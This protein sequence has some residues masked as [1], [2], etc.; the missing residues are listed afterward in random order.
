MRLFV[1]PLTSRRAFVYGHRV[2]QPAQKPS[3]IDRAI[4]KS[5][6]LWLKWEKHEKG[7]KKH[8]TTW[9]NGMLRRIPYHEWSLKSIPAISRGIPDSDRQKV[10]VVY[11]PSV[12]TQVEI[13]GLLQKLGTEKSGEHKRRLM[14]C[15]IGMP[16]TIPFAA[17]PIIPNLPFFY[18][19]F[20]AYSH[21]RAIQGGR[22]LQFLVHKN[23]LDPQPDTRLDMI[24]KSKIET[25]AKNVDIP[26]EKIIKAAEAGVMDEA[27]QEHLNEELEL[28]EHPKQIAEALEIPQLVVEIERACEQVHEKLKKA[29]E[30]HEKPE[31]GLE[32]DQKKQ[33]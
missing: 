17:I 10:P 23:L 8:V 3:I 7:W 5:S 31:E 21:W 30:N 22:H 20:R 6:D 2:V 16:L 18:L 33:N 29:K 14:W 24:Y 27:A 1:I 9:G 4:T 26:A 15:F 12:M 25:V 28:I 13:P 32:R 11:P 19:V